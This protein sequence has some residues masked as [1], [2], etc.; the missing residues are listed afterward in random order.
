M[1]SVTNM[2]VGL[3]TVIG[4]L[5]VVGLILYY[6]AK[7]IGK[8][9]PPAPPA[10]PGVDYMQ[11]IGSRCPSYWVYGGQTNYGGQPVDKCINA[12]NV[13]VADDSCYDDPTNKVAYFPVIGNYGDWR[14]KD[15]TGSERCK[16]VRKCGMPLDPKKHALPKC[17][18]PAQIAANDTTCGAPPS[19]RCPV[20]GV[21][22]PAGCQ[23]VDDAALHAAWVGVADKC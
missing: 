10:W 5:V 23:D 12:F 8:Y 15:I 2:I 22:E 21:E 9:K 19:C 20:Q 3:F 14:K 16:W 4:I 13:A 1:V 18:T 11:Y 17:C 6:I 7:A